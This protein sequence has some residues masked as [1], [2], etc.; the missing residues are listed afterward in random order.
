MTTALQAAIV[1]LA[2]IFLLSTNAVYAET[3]TATCYSPSGIR[4]DFVDGDRTEDED[5][6]SNSTPT[7]F[8]STNDPEY[9]IESW[10]AALP[11]PDLM[12]R[13]HADEIAPPSVTKSAVVYRSETVIHAVSIQ[14]RDAYTTTLYLDKGVAI[15]TR[16]RVIL[17]G[18]SSEP[19]GAIY[20][21]KCNFSVLP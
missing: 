3:V 7:F 9:L 16:I 4:F 12:D 6:Y 20:S 1:A 19:M 21:A 18:F 11:F 15:F 14:S 2:G 17:D 10:Q 8:Y 5:G 13:E